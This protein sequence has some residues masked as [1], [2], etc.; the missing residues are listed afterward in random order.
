M[1]INDLNAADVVQTV[2]EIAAE[3]PDHSDAGCVY[4]H[5]NGHPSC[6]VGH[7]LYRL[8]VRLRD[9]SVNNNGD[10]IDEL[11]PFTWDEGDVAWLFSVQEYQDRLVPWGAA[12][13]HA[14]RPY[15]V[16]R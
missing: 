9:L 2:R 16:T 6:I 4:F 13:E 7:A 14:D 10:T 15:K 8:G 3:R 11:A 1:N 5:S 12:V